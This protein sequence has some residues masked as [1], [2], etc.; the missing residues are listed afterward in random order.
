MK[1][2]QF[3]SNVEPPPFFEKLKNAVDKSWD[4]LGSVGCKLIK[5]KE[6]YDVMFFPA[7]R[8]VYGGKGDGEMIY[9][10]FNFNIGRFVRV[11]DKPPKANFDTLRKCFI[12]HMQFKGCI[13][14]IVCKIN[15]L[16]CPPDNL[17]AAERVYTTG[18]NK[19]KIEVIKQ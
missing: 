13:N 8:E 15:I 11:F 10:G 1:N 6:G 18:P 5:S 7:L 12:P 3:L 16:Q 4:S 14:G 17:R 2:Y 9:P 19:G